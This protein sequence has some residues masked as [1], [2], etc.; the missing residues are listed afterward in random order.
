MTQAIFVPKVN[1]VA[2]ID[3]VIAWC[4]ESQART[5]DAAVEEEIKDLQI[6]RL[7]VQQEWPLSQGVKETIKIGPFAV[8][9][10]ADWNTGLSKALTIL[11]HVLKHDGDSIGRL[12]T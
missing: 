12:G 3:R 7:Q 2:A 9:N 4:I 5:P 11:H 1:V 10:I 8:K 6:L